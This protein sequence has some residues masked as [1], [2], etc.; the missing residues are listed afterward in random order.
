MD[1]RNQN[2]LLNNLIIPLYSSVSLIPEPNLKT[3]E[4]SI[5]ENPQTK[6]PLSAIYK[7]RSK[8]DPKQLKSKVWKGFIQFYFPDKDF[9]ILTKNDRLFLL[10]NLIKLEEIHN[11]Q[12]YSFKISSLEKMCFFISKEKTKRR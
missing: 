9:Q 1:F 5:Q 8:S 10:N 7:N 11:S 4:S 3:S 12:R 6:N 2:P